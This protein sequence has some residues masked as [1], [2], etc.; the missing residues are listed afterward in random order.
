MLL[1]RILLRF[2]GD[3][4]R[5]EPV[6]ADLAE[7]AV[8]QRKNEGHCYEVQAKESCRSHLDAIDGF[9]VE[10]KIRYLYRHLDLPRRVA[11][12]DRGE[13]YEDRKAPVFDPGSEPLVL[14]L[15]LP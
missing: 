14:R 2:V 10:G 12:G 13:A 6:H 3:I 9:G 5:F 8:V 7:P 11:G 4:L 1:N 15:L